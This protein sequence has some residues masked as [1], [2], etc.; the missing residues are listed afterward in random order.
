MTDNQSINPNRNLDYQFYFL[1]R[2]HLWKEEQYIREP[3][4]RFGDLDDIGIQID[5]DK[6]LF[7]PETPTQRPLDDWQAYLKIAWEGILQEYCEAFNPEA[8]D[9]AKDTARH[10]CQDN[11]LGVALLIMDEAVDGHEVTLD[12][13]DSHDQLLGDAGFSYDKNVLLT[14]QDKSGNMPQPAT[15]HA[16]I[17]SVNKRLKTDNWALGLDKEQPYLKKMPAAETQNE[18]AANAQN[19]PVFVVYGLAHGDALTALEQAQNWPVQLQTILLTE[20]GEGPLKRTAILN[21][22]LARLLIS[23]AVF[24]T[25]SKTLRQTPNRVLEEELRKMEALVVQTEAYT[26]GR[27]SQA[28]K[29]LEINQ[30]NFEWRLNHM[31]SEEA[32]WQIDWQSTGKYPPL[33]EPLHTGIANLKNHVAYIEGKLTHLKGAC[34]RWRSHISESRYNWSEHMG[35]LG[36]IIILLV[37]LAEMGNVLSQGAGEASSHGTEIVSFWASVSNNLVAFFNHPL[38]YVI[39]IGLYLIFVFPVLI[40]KLVKW[41][42]YQFRK[43]VKWFKYQ[44]RNSSSLRGK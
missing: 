4:D 32:E 10:F 21:S 17:P 43:F 8:P 22:I 13:C 2:T 38:P 18:L 24:E 35:Y 40:N 31:Q 9:E 6:R 30:D 7:R 5:T 23:E 36:H 16:F 39:V 42:K 33:L 28:I 41:S 25:S 34:T 37:T 29:T 20:V 14:I 1:F 44:F 26:L 3:F 27:L 11:L 15:L 12:L 19:Y